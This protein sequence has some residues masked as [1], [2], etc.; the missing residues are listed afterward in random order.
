MICC[1]FLLLFGLRLLSAQL[2]SHYDDGSYREFLKRTFY[3][4][5]SGSRPI[6]LSLPFW[7]AFAKPAAAESTASQL[8]YDLCSSFRSNSQIVA[9]KGKTIGST[10][11][12]DAECNFRIE[13]SFCDDGR[14]SCEIG[15][16]GFTGALECSKLRIGDRCGSDLDCSLA[17]ANSIC[18]NSGF[19]ACPTGFAVT[20]N[21]CEENAE[22]S[23]AV[24]NSECTGNRCVCQ[25]DFVETAD[26]KCGGC[27]VDE[28]LYPEGASSASCYFASDNEL[29]WQEAREICQARGMD[30]VSL[31]SS[32]EETFVASLFTP[33][34]TFWIGLNDQANEGSYV[35]SDGTELDYPN[36][37]G[38]N[39]PTGTTGQ[40]CVRWYADTGLWRDVSCDST[41]AFA[42]KGDLV[43]QRRRRYIW[44]G[45]W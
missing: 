7:D 22:C 36:W 37:D 40:N 8:D 41:F 45:L 16:K 33:L 1:V 13:E 3:F 43:V 17:I 39:D 30:L 20:R 19:C 11:Q 2:P 4:N 15:F 18:D 34:V 38:P 21:G 44:P 26:G 5:P 9:P 24:A 42:C 27:N 25:T 10:C 32:E 14:C 31:H 35:W 23:T 12:C 29:T 6:S 28:E